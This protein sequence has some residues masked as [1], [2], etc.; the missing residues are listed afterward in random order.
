MP[1]TTGSRSMVSGMNGSGARASQNAK[2]THS[3][4]EAATQHRGGCDQAED[5]QRSPW[6]AHAAPGEREEERNGGGDHQR[7]AGEIQLVRAL[8]A[9][10]ATQ[11]AVGHDQ[12]G[13]AHRQIDPKDQRPVHVVG[14]HAAEHRPEDAGSHE[15]GR[16]IGLDQRALAR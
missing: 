10:Q 2:L 14:Q 8:I 4:A 5:R 7:G 6:V 12:G 1:N 16:G 3:T 9:R 11:R 15:H 13:D